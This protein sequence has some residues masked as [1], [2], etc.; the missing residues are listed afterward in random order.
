[1]LAGWGSVSLV[2]CV[3][4]SYGAWMD[5][6]DGAFPF[7]R[8]LLRFLPAKLTSRFLFADFFPLKRGV[9]FNFLNP[10]KRVVEFNLNPP[11]LPIH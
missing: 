9:E 5:V 7:G 2:W 1:M 4:G 6:M 3:R 10:P 11:K 8:F